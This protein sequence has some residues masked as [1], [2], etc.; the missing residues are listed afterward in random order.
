VT[1]FHSK[2]TLLFCSAGFLLPVVNASTVATYTFNNTLSAQQSGVAALSAVDPLGTS[3]FTTANVF[4]NL[5][6]VYNFNGASTPA[7]QGGLDLN[8]TGL[9][10][11]SD[12][13]VEM[14]VEL[15][16][17]SGWRRLLDSQDRQSDAGYY[18]DPDN[19]IDNFPN[20][21]GTVNQ[22]TNNT[23]FDIFVT[24]NPSNN[25]VGYLNGGQQ[26]ADI[27]TSLDVATNT[28]GF[29]LD[30]TAGGGQGEWSSGDVAL[31]KVFNTALTADQVEEESAHPFAGTGGTATP[32]PGTWILLLAGAAGIAMWKRRVTA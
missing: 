4:G 19:A 7:D 32:E 20:G 10:S 31:I 15:T 1:W 8:T 26:F 2:F 9:I 6:T 25:V 21:G 22:F 5:Q 23:F 11:G 29:F 16:S 27:S 12:Y 24:V 18:I 30:N 28:L 14:V 17:D 13:S 3:G